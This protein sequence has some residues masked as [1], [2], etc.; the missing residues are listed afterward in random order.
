M[1]KFNIVGVPTIILIDSNGN[2]VK[3]ITSFIDADNFM[4]VLKE[5]D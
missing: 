4:N 1:K 5:V 3:R 2:E